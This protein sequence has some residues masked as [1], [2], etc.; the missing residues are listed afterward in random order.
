MTNLDPD[1]TGAMIVRASEAG[2]I[3]VVSLEGEARAAD[4][5]RLQM[6]FMRLVVRRVPLVVLDLGGLRFLSSLALGALVA[7]RRDLARFGGRVSL[8]GARPAVVEVLEATRFCTLF[9]CY[10]TVEE[11]VAAG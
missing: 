3:W 1:L 6:P 4:V 2:G 8:A 7:L 10:A 5:G 11:A 9:A